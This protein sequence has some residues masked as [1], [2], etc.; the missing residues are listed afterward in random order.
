MKASLLGK[1]QLIHR[2]SNNPATGPVGPDITIHTDTKYYDVDH[3]FY[4]VTVAAT[5]AITV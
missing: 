2:R 1:V 4:P 5:A 3:D